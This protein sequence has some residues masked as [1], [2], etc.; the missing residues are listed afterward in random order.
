MCAIQQEV[1][2]L[3]PR[4]GAGAGAIDGAVVGAERA[5][6]A[7]MRSKLMPQRWGRVRASVT[8]RLKA[9]IVSILLKMVQIQGSSFLSTI[10]RGLQ[11][12]A[13][14]FTVVE[15][16][17]G[18]QGSSSFTHSGTWS[19]CAFADPD[20]LTIT[21]MAITTT[22]DFTFL[23]IFSL[24][25]LW[26]FEVSS[27]MLPGLSYNLQVSDTGTYPSIGPDISQTLGHG[28]SVMKLVTG[29]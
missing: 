9:W 21:M 28:D 25:T 10:E 18:P 11:H 8:L 14:G 24:F 13:G 22:N 27:P 23:I 12:S 7:E 29:A 1:Q 19:S 20:E 5:W 3:A 2:S 26:P 15:L 17:N 16:M 6:Q 4:D